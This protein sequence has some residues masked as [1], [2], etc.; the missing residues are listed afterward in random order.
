MSR[1]LKS[2]VIWLIALMYFCSKM[3][4][5][6][7]LFWLPL[8][9]TEHLGYGLAEAGYTSIL[10]E[11]VGFL[12]V[13]AAGYASDKLFQSRRMPV[14]ALGMW[15]LAIACFIFPQMSNGGHVTTAIGISLMGFFCFGPHGVEFT[16]K[17]LQ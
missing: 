8:Y 7:L 15:G 3:G 12:G 2:Q 14:G 9:L 6:A 1:V 16:M 4:R 5:Y 17:L 13:L 10:Y 11:A